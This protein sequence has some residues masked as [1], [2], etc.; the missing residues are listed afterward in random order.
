MFEEMEREC[1][2]TEPLAFEESPKK[3]DETT[4][5]PVEIPEPE[6]TREEPECGPEAI[7]L[8]MRL[9]SGEKVNRTHKNTKSQT[10]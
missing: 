2:E 9:P 5:P 10:F 8:R 6:Y 3:V 7:K 4:V 1:F